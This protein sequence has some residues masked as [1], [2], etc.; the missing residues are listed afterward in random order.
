M[1]RARDVC[2]HAQVKRVCDGVI[3]FPPVRDSIPLSLPLPVQEKH[4]FR[5]RY[6]VQ[7]LAARNLAVFSRIGHA[8][9]LYNLHRLR[10][11]ARLAHTAMQLDDR[12]HPLIDTPKVTELQMLI[13]VG[14]GD[15]CVCNV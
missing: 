7:V 1:E 2:A 12:A 11:P 6:V 9:S 10:N 15:A 4:I 13:C 5:M 14:A 3:M 8:I